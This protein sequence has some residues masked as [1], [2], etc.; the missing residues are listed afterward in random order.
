MLNAFQVSS[1][2][3]NFCNCWETL[4]LLF[5]FCCF[6]VRRLKK[7]NGVCTTKLRFKAGGNPRHERPFHWL[8]LKSCGIFYENPDLPIW[9]FV[10]LCETIRFRPTLFPEIGHKRKIAFL[11]LPTL[12]KQYPASKKV[13]DKMWSFFPTFNFPNWFSCG[14]LKKGMP[15]K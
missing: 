7:E 3:I 8:Q 5:Y 4:K 10:Y 12:E 11:V 13:L 2:P 1:D 9:T 14:G 6:N 15:L